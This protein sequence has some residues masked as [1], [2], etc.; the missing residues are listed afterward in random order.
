M[1]GLRQHVMEQ[2]ELERFS[3]RDYAIALAVIDALDDNGYLG[4]SLEEIAEDLEALDPPPDTVEI[5]AV[6]Q[7]VQRL[8]PV[9]IAARSAAEC[10]LLQLDVLPPQ[11]PALDTAQAL[12]SAHFDRL[13]R[14]DMASLVRLTREDE[15][16][17]QAALSLIQS[18][19]PRPGSD[20]S[21]AATEYLIPELRVRRTPDGWHVEPYP[22]MR[23]VVTVNETYA[24]WL[25][26]HR[27]E[28]NAQ[29]LCQQL[30]EARWLVRSLAQREETLL[31]VARV[32][33]RHQSAFLEHGP[34]R[35]TPLTLREVAEELE[36]HESTVSRAVQGKAL[37]TPRGVILLRHLFSNKVSN[38]SDEG[39]SATSVRERLRYLLNHEDPTAPLSD[40]ALA[41]ALAKENMPIARRTVAKYREALGFASTRER[42]RPAHSSATSKR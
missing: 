41:Q 22:G 23:P 5:E 19:N 40:A 33:V 27:Q 14:A 42:R 21:A 10:L 35:L 17:V 39:L 13:A 38:N 26:A 25:N 6:L 9:G 30:E 34:L 29:I 3:A 37:A 20:F 32:L 18:L 15:D 8:E 16:T 36:V 31:R 12:I 1:P 7:R 28:P 2:L 24:K 4:E 11:T